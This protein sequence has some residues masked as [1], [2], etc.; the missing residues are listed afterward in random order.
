MKSNNSIAN[1]GRKS[2]REW[3][4]S[5]TFISK[6]PVKIKNTEVT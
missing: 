5:G 3:N 2:A 6:T 1:D 4:K